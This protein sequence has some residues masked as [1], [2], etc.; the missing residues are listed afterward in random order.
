MRGLEE[1][2]RLP[3]EGTETGL[4]EWHIPTDTVEWSDKVCPLYGPPR[5]TQPSGVS[6]VLERIVHPLDREALSERLDAAVR[7]GTPY[8]FDQRVAAPGRP[9]RWLHTRAI[10]VAGADGRTERITGLVSDVTERR[11]R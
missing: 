3:L 11:H 10:P 8:E 7:H 1:R 6:D 4:W 5:G 2:L 9:E